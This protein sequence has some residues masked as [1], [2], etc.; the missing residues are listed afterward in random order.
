MRD[1]CRYVV[2]PRIDQ[3]TCLKA[4]VAAGFEAVPVG[5]RLEAYEVRSDLDAIRET[6]QRLGP[7]NVACVLT[8]TS[9]FAP[10]G[11]D[12]IVDVVSFQQ[13]CYCAH[14]CMSKSYCCQDPALSTVDCAA[15]WC[16]VADGIL[17][18]HV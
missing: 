1:T 14:N 4:I 9:C 5:N 18:E 12:C 10:R 17:D 7:Q 2:W 15:M 11:A 8:T 16:A 3:K 6:I 13:A